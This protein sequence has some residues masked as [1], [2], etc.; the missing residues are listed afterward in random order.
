MFNSEYLHQHWGLFTLASVVITL[1]ESI[2]VDTEFLALGSLLCGLNCLVVGS[3]FVLFVFNLSS[4]CWIYLD[5]YA[6]MSNRQRALLWYY[7]CDLPLLVCAC[8]IHLK[9]LCFLQCLRLLTH[10]FN[11]EYSHVCI[12]ASESKVVLN[13]PF[14]TH[15]WKER[16]SDLMSVDWFLTVERACIYVCC[17]FR[18]CPSQC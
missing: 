5:V 16:K 6:F 3:E 13:L 8:R 14:Q 18:R 1:K 15:T 2:Y 9:L 10:S 12:S 4:L 17:R 11:R 7:R